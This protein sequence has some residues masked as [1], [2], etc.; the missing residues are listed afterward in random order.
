[1]FSI[2]SDASLYASMDRFVLRASILIYLPLTAYQQL[3]LFGGKH[4]CHK[5]EFLPP[6]MQ[7]KIS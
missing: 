5:D 1:M 7:K 4:R 6:L 3:E 2:S